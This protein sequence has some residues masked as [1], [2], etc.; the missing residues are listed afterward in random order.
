M[1]VRRKTEKIIQIKKEKEK[2]E[3]KSAFIGVINVSQ[4]V[5]F[6]KK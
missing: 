6:G 5:D 4:V 2:N 3:I 1:C